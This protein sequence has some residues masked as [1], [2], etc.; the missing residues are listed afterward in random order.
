VLA[1]LVV[2]AGLGWCYLA[3]SGDWRGWGIAEMRVK[4]AMS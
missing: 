2:V 1:V 4:G 3:R